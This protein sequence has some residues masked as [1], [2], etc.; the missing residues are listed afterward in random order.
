MLLP[1]DDGPARRHVSARQVRMRRILAA[2][3]ATDLGVA[4]TDLVDDGDRSYPGVLL[5]SGTSSL[6]QTSPQRI[7]PPA[8]RRFLL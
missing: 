4:L 5:N 1:E 3:A 7:G 2:N 6:S 8:E